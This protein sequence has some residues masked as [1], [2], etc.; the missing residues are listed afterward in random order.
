MQKTKYANAYIINKSMVGAME[1]T[2]TQY[3]E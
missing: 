2:I 1:K 3:V